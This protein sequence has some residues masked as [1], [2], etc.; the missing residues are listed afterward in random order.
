MTLGLGNISIAGI[1]LQ[2]IREAF[3]EVSLF[4]GIVIDR[5]KYV[6]YNKS[7]YIKITIGEG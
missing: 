4:Y 1:D 7:T 2:M 3:I 6:W 5:D